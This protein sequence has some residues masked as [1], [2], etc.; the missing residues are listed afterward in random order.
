ME[1]VELRK[2][3]RT[4]IDTIRNI[5]WKL[6]DSSEE[7][8]SIL[9]WK[10]NIYPVD[11]DWMGY[12]DREEMFLIYYDSELVGAVALSK[13]RAKSY[14]DIR[15]TIDAF[16]DETAVI[17]LFVVDPEYQG[18]GIATAAL[19]ELI[20]IAKE[21]KKKAVRLDAIGTNKPA[22]KLYEK[23]GFINCG[24]AMEYYESTGKTEF[25]YYE[26]IV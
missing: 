15:W 26:Y 6:L 18:K 14:S 9:Q 8:A 16:D 1:N 22:P 5:Y 10:K 19:D 21:T 12:I 7:Y 4:D 3:K 11:S 17:H 23:Y 25:V 24:K 2:A 13:K 20:R